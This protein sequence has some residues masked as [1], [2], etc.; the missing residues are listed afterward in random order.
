ML[1]VCRTNY[2]VDSKEVR[3]QVVEVLSALREKHARE[4]AIPPSTNQCEGGGRGPDSKK[5]IFG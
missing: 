5:L 2:R 4:V 1:V 3:W